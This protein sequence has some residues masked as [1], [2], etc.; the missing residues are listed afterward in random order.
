MSFSRSVFLLTLIVPGTLAGQSVLGSSGLGLRSEPLDAVQRALGGMGVTTRR[1]AV[2]PG[3]PLASLDILAPTIAFTAQP[4][5]G[6]F[7]VGS[8]RGNFLMTRFPVLGFAYPLGTKGVVTLTAGS[9]FDQNWSVESKDSVDIAG[10]TVGITDTFLSEG[11]I[12]AIQ[13]GW[14]RRWTNTLASGVTLGVY[15]GGLARSFTRR[16][17]LVP[18]DT[19]FLANPIAGSTNLGR[20]THSGPLASVNVSW[21]PSAA[22][23]LGATLG[24]GG[25]IR[26]DPEEGFATAN[27]K[28]SIPLEVKVSAIAVLS[29]ALA[30]NAGVA[31]SNWQ[32]LGDPDIDAVAGGRVLSYGGGMEL[33]VL[34]FWAGG[35]PLRLGYRRSELPFRFL[36]NRVRESVVS[37]GITVVLAQA[38][39]V[40]LAALDVAFESGNRKSG[41][42]KES[43]RRLTITLVVG[44]R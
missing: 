1:A 19:I 18:A 24:W 34:S 42:Y 33:E 38:L 6:K 4:Q 36:G 23:Q 35:L 32:D 2:L 16:F 9:Q 43:L 37:F 17:D 11:G 25:T 20:W 8:E 22:L 39:D 41:N 44:G 28:V 12:V 27:R 3:N 31:S 40:P 29:P 10:G 7:T 14:A 5:W 13:A 26:V 30:L 21:D 15:R